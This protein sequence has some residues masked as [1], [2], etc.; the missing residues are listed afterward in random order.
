MCVSLDYLFILGKRGKSPRKRVPESYKHHQYTLKAS[1]AE[2][3][4]NRTWSALKEGGGYSNNKDNPTIAIILFVFVFVG[5]LFLNTEIY[6]LTYLR[7]ETLQE[8]I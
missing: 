4:Q 8:T 3:C 2:Y 5:Q 1:S 6:G 7:L